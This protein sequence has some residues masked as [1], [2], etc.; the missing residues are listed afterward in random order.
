MPAEKESEHAADAE[1]DDVVGGRLK[2]G[3]D[4]GEDGDL[5]DVCNDGQDHGDTQAGTG[6]DFDGF[7]I[8]VSRLGHGSHL[9]G[10][11]RG[12]ESVGRFERASPQGLKPRCFCVRARHE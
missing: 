2:A 10:S 8:E 12:G 9:Q 5:K 11:A 7:A 3:D 6:G 1:V 4:E